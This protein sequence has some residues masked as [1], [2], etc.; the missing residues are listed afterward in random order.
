MDH[1]RLK[2]N[3]IASFHDLMKIRYVTTEHPKNLFTRDFGLFGEFVSVVRVL[4]M[5]GIFCTVGELGRAILFH[6]SPYGSKTTIRRALSH[7]V[8][9][10][11]CT[12][13]SR[14]D[15]VLIRFNMERLAYWT[16][17]KT[18]TVTPINTS[19]YNSHIQSPKNGEDPTENNNCVN[20]CY[21][22]NTSKLQHVKT[23]KWHH[24]VIYTLFIVLTRLRAPDRAPLISRAELEIAAE[25]S[26]N[27]LVS[28]SGVP[29]ADHES[30]WP[31]MSHSEREG[32]A[33]AD[34]LPALRNAVHGPG[35]GQ[36]G[37]GQPEAPPLREKLVVDLHALGKLLA[38]R[39]QAE[40][41][42][43]PAPVKIASTLLDPASLQ[44]LLKARE[45][46][47]SRAIDC[48]EGGFIPNVARV[49]VR[50]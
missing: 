49:N 48:D 28:P 9:L 11:Y 7:L 42:P 39:K 22:G 31:S 16:E 41:S 33:R 12:V 24:P 44:I 14:R 19:S 1:G 17:K 40:F 32:I 5:V 10:G 43:A 45:L 6:G 29:W 34:I 8:M 4:S 13:T 21:S 30:R 46:A 2:R 38:T 27:E 20:T 37:D 3:K 25:S 15:G 26:G 18:D 50:S 47:S 36:P 35:D 23:V